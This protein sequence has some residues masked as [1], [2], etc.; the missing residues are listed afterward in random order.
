MK[1]DDLSRFIEHLPFAT[2]DHLRPL[3]QG[4]AEVIL[5]QGKT[6]EQVV[7]IAERP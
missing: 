3:T 6:A 1:L 5:C 7:A 2:I 4:H